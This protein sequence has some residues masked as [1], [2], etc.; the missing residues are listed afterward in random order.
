[1]GGAI[2]ALKSPIT[3]LIF[4]I[5]VR[6]AAELNA[7]DWKIIDGLI[8]TSEMLRSLVQ[9]SVV[10]LRRLEGESRDPK[11][12]AYPEIIRKLMP[13]TERMAILTIG[14]R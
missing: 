1:M 6:Q 11:G 4:E 13:K 9:V 2:A 14:S 8:S 12:I 7:V 10:F 5:L 3:H